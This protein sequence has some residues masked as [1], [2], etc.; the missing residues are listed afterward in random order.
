MLAALRGGAEVRDE[1]VRLSEEGARYLEDLAIDVDRLELGESVESRAT[2][3]VRRIS[4][5]AGL[6]AVGLLSGPPEPADRAVLVAGAC[7]RILGYLA[8]ADELR[9][10]LNSQRRAAEGRGPLSTEVYGAPVSLDWFRLHSPIPEGVAP[11]A[12]LARW[13]A[14][15]KDETGD[16]VVERRDEGGQRPALVRVTPARR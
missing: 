10:Y 7:E 5:L 2:A 9:A 3:A 6:D 4:L 13:E 14:A 11:D 12:W 15:G 1:P 8:A 16:Y